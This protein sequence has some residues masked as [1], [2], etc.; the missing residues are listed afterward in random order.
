M[1]VYAIRDLYGE[2]I[3]EHGLRRLPDGKKRMWWRL[4]GMSPEDGLCGL[5]TLDLPLYGSERIGQLTTGQTVVVT[6]GEG[7]CEALWEL[8]IDALGTVTGAGSTPGEDALSPLLPFDVVLWPDHDQ[9][10]SSHMARV[11]ATLLRIGG[12]CRL[13]RW[14][15]E[16]GDDAAD[17]VQRG[18]SSD[19]ALA[20]LTA[21]K[22]IEAVYREPAAPQRPPEPR[23]G[24]FSGTEERTE[25]A[26]SHLT[27]VA[28]EKLGQPARQDRRS[29]WWCCP[30]HD[31]RTPSF[32]VD[33]TEPYY[34]CYGCGAR[35]DVFTFLKAI[36]GRAFR[37][38][39]TTL[40]PG[41]GA[42]PRLWA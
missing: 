26:R 42:I 5:S 20:L 8:G 30:F 28:F 32:K 12:H 4:P 38:V 40:A 34:V 35:G 3:A 6:E 19:D 15:A 24:R 29:L 1:H 39:L 41:I 27:Q 36:E 33:L 14:G 17:F 2:V 31:D 22:P 18:G 21:A 13:L 7:A 10:G 9:D 11:A 37:E 16:K 23:Y 25:Q